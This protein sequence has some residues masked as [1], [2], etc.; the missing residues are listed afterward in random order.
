MGNDY[1][2]SE[3]SKNKAVEKQQKKKE[4]KKH[5][6]IGEVNMSEEMNRDERTAN[7]DER[8]VKHG[9]W[10]LGCAFVVVLFIIGL[11]ILKMS[12]AIVPAGYA[13]VKYNMS[14]GVEG[15][16]LSQ[17]WHLK[18]PT[19]K[20]TLYTIGI[21]QSYLT[22]GKKGDSP[23]NDSFSASSAEGKAMQIDLTYTYKYDANKVSDVFTKFKGQ[24]GTEVRDSFI[25]PNI[26]SW[27]KEVVA[28]YKVS[29]ILG[30][31]RANVNAAITDYLA[32]KFEPYG[33]LISNVSL[34]DVSVDDATMQSINAKIQAQQNAE[35]QKIQNQTAVDKAK[36]DA[37]VKKT[38]AQ[39]EAD[40]ELIKAEAEAKA[41]SKLSASIT[42]EL[43]KMK[44]AEARLK[45]GWVTVQGSDTVVTDTTDNSN[46]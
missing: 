18:S 10:K 12:L 33:I 32:N 26:I 46:N 42:N 20:V 28:K 11:I 1:E 23:D 14:G 29:D 43:I 17:G 38:N 9:H 34:I 45:H 13:G 19:V 39:A 8:T 22:A 24:S 5:K 2:W 6:E 3:Y 35:T 7:R 44:E 40:A 36:A 25:K 37:E 16:T 15:D 21:E 27:T 30:S 41:N 31:E 4:K